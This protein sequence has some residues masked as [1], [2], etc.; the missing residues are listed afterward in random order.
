LGALAVACLLT[1]EFNRR[2]QTKR[3]LL[4]VG[5]AFM[6]EVVD[7]A[8]KDLATRAWFA[9]P[10]LY[11]NLLIPLLIALWMLWR[12]SAPPWRRR[13]FAAQPAE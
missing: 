3:I 9:I 7:V 2:G 6:V 1:G 8:L 5:L 10:L 11:A 4:A 12:E 13:A